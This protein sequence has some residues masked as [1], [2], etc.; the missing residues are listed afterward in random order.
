MKLKDPIFFEQPLAQN[1]KTTLRDWCQ[2]NNPHFANKYYFIPK[3]NSP[4]VILSKSY[5]YKSGIVVILNSVFKLVFTEIEKLV[6]S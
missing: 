5:I 4:E 6:E 1:Y 3:Y 2:K